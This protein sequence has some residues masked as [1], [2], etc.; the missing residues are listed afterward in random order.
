M[1]TLPLQLRLVLI[2]EGGAYVIL[3]IFI[4]ITP[5]QC[6]YP[7]KRANFA[8]EVD[9][10]RRYGCHTALRFRRSCGSPTKPTDFRTAAAIVM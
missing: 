9:M 3:L 2:K 6:A 4:I 8:A 7:K 1:A 10:S 5:T